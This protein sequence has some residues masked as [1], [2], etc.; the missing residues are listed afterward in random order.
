M[1]V[2]YHQHWI[3]RGEPVTW[4]AHSPDLSPL[5]FFFWGHIKSLMYQSPV[6]SAEDLVVRNIVAAD[7]ISMTPETFKRVRQSLIRRCEL[8]NTANAAILNS[9]FAF[10]YANKF[11]CTT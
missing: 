10:F 6:E 7:K 4:P 9:Y 2:T 11:V 3:R 5:D 8:R 1:D